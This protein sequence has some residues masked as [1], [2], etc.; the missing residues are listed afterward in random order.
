[1]NKLLCCLLF[2][3]AVGC[4]Q[5]QQAKPAPEVPIQWTFKLQPIVVSDVWQP[6]KLV[7][8]IRA[9]NDN[10]RSLGIA[11]EM[12]KPIYAVGEVPESAGSLEDLHKLYN[13]FYMSNA[14]PVLLV[15]HLYD[16]YVGF[17]FYPPDPV[18]CLEPLALTDKN[19]LTH[20]LGHAFGLKDYQ[21]K[22]EDCL[23]EDRRY[24]WMSYCFF[25]RRMFADEEIAAIT[26]EA[27]KMF[28]RKASK[29]SKRSSEV[30]PR[31]VACPSGDK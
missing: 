9:A 16:G 13:R 20:E 14:I 10:Y 30:M 5:P 12:L 4:V 15:K 17:A 1:M 22:M 26:T 6:D 23:Y 25:S 2:L 11:F 27:A 28:N 24:R 7:P 21:G 19:T 31:H 8:S 3:F 29:L 18:I